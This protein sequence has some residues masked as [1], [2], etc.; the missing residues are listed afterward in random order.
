MEQSDNIINQIE[1]A[2]LP[3][4]QPFQNE[5]NFILIYLNK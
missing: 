5:I 1:Q 4:I 3:L 2:I